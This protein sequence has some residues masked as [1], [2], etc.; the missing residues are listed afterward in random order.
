M[1]RLIFLRQAARRNVIVEL[2][3]FCNPYDDERLAWFP[4][5]RDSN[6]NGVGGGMTSIF[7]FMERRDRTV[8]E[9]QKAFMSK[10]VEELNEFDNLYFEISNE[11]STR[12]KEPEFAKAQ[13]EWHVALARHIRE[14]E[15]R[16]ANRHLIA[17]NAHQRI[18][19]YVENGQEFT[20][21][22]DAA[23]FDEPSVDIINYHY[24]SRK[25]PGKGLAAIDS[26][27]A[28]AGLTS[29]YFKARRHVRKPIVFDENYAGVVR[30]AAADWGRNRMEAWE[31]ILSG[32]AG[33]DHLD[34]SFT[35]QDPT[36]S[37]KEPI[38]DGRRLDGRRLRAQLGRLASLW[39]E[40]GPDWMRPDDDMVA[41]SPE[42]TQAFAST[43]SDG[44]RH[45]VYVADTRQEGFGSA[46]GGR[47]LLR[48]AN[49]AY[50]IRSL[51]S[52]ALEWETL[53]PVKA[54]APA[55]GIDLPPFQKDCV[56]VMDKM[57]LP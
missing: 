9:A 44:R 29:A 2:V 11:T 45:V 21:T 39:R 20:E 42:N 22:G 40:S 56:L 13:V 1:C 47:I 35:P 51:P 17:V 27:P 10:V 34:W 53:P 25:A 24:I 18:L 32:G 41:S 31:T 12:R 48:L 46:I 7:H 6:V 15:S 54:R 49:G 14:V 43:R 26:G 52:G 3:F 4:F 55:T 50:S 28:R 8:F 36:G 38:A 57:D 23:Y 19:K 16:L 30:G 37:G 33:F 5:H